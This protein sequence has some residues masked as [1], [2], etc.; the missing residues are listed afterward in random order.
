MPRLVDKAVDVV[1]R[2]G[3]LE[4][5]ARRVDLQP[6]KG[7]CQLEGFGKH[8]LLGHS[9]I[10]GTTGVMLAVAGRRV[11]RQDLRPTLASAEFAHEDAQLVTLTAKAGHQFQVDSIPASV[12]AQALP[13]PLG[14]RLQPVA[15]T[16]TIVSGR[17][18]QQRLTVTRQGAFGHGHAPLCR[19]R[20]IDHARADFEADTLAPGRMQ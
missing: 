20:W 12:L 11:D 15:A 8:R 2:I 3:Q 18:Q 9:D 14:G 6:G 7:R 4:S 17:L 1:A 13:G 19:D 5:E 10:D 16:E